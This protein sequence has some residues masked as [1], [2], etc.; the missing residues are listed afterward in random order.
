VILAAY[1]GINA[2]LSPFDS[3][4]DALIAPLVH[5]KVVYLQHGVLHASFLHTYPAELGFADRVVI[6]SAFEL[7]NF[8][9]TYHYAPRQL[10]PYG[11]PRYEVLGDQKTPSR[12][13]LF[14]PSWRSFLAPHNPSKNPTVGLYEDRLAVSD[15]YSGI[16]AFLMSKELTNVLA[17]NDFWLEFKPHP[18]MEKLADE[19]SGLGDRVSVITGE[20]DP[21]QYAVFITDFSSFVFDFVRLQTP[22]LYFVPDLDDFHSGANQ[23]RELDMALDDGFGPVTYDPKY[24]VEALASVLS[25]D[26]A[27]EPLYSERMGSFFLKADNSMGAI[28]DACIREF[29]I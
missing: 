13:I 4:E 23:Y 29:G 8:A 10:W 15:Y 3:A 20:I 7:E 25:R 12:R 17:E 5:H 28:Y 27:V 22:V 26:C 24:A 1:I 2:Q 19:L 14:A 16:M 9:K 11:S 21:R 18:I 6:S